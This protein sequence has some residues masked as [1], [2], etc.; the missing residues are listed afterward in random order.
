MPWTEVPPKTCWKARPF[1]LRKLMFFFS[2]S[3]LWH[4][5][6]CHVFFAFEAS[7]GN[8]GSFLSHGLMAPVFD[9]SNGM[10]SQVQPGH[11]SVAVAP[12]LCSTRSHSRFTPAK[13]FRFYISLLPNCLFHE[14]KYRLFHTQKDQKGQLPTWTAGTAHSRVAPLASQELTWDNSWFRIWKKGAN[15]QLHILILSYTCRMHI[16]LY[17]CR[18]ANIKSV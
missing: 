10:P 16:E 8:V 17:S 1:K 15:V 13:M 12:W 6:E 18:V 4:T 5:D 11:P 14:Q 3:L 7:L 2:M 9:V